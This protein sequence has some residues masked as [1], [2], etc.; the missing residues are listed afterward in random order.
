VGHLDALTH[1]GAEPGKGLLLHI[2][3]A[4]RSGAIHCDRYRVAR[5]QPGRGAPLPQLPGQVVGVLDS[6]V[7]AEPTGRRVDD[8]SRVAACK[9]NTRPAGTILPRATWAPMLNPSTLRS[10][11]RIWGHSLTSTTREGRPAAVQTIPTTRSRP[12]S[13]LRSTRA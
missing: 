1:A 4:V 3:R 12:S 13:S 9:E 11:P 5:H 7:A 10:V 8:T 6:S 2:L